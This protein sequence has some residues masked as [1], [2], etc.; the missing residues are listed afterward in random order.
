MDDKIILKKKKKKRQKDKFRR[1]QWRRE[2]YFKKLQSY[3]AKKE[4]DS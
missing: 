2:F 1:V 3:S 4:I